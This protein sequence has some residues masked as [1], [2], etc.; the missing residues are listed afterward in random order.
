ML[1]QGDRHAVLALRKKRNIRMEMR[2]KAQ[3]HRY[4]PSF[5]S[6]VKGGDSCNMIKYVVKVSQMMRRDR[7]LLRQKHPFF[8]RVV[9]VERSRAQ[10]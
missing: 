5:G 2:E 4:S 10:A 9:L 1:A 8:A 6:D 3:R 7:F